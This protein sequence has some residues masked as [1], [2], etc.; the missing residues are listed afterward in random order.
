MPATKEGYGG[1][2]NTTPSTSQPAAAIAWI[3]LWLII[4]FACREHGLTGCRR[5]NCSSDNASTESLPS[6]MARASA[7]ACGSRHS[8]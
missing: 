6:V 2:Q 3:S 4:G 5:Q 1:A 7:A 8:A